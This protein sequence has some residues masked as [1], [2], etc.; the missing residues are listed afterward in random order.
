MVDGPGG[1][2][3]GGVPELGPAGADA[4]G[5]GVDAMVADEPDLTS[6]LLLAMAAGLCM[7]RRAANAAEPRSDHR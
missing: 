6:G 5:V 7:P 4:A 3:G 1:R 2:V